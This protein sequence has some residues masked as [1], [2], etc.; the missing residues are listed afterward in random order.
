M[1]VIQGERDTQ[2]PDNMSF[3]NLVVFF[4]SR[5]SFYKV[6]AESAVAIVVVA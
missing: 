5:G 3:L 1:I 4:H 2:F 6:G